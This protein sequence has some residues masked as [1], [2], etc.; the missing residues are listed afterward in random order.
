MVQRSSDFSPFLTIQSLEGK[1][2]LSSRWKTN[3]GRRERGS[4]TEEEVNKAGEK[5]KKK[6]LATTWLAKEG[7][8]L[9]V[10]AFMTNYLDYVL[11]NMKTVLIYLR[12]KIFSEM[13]CFQL[14]MHHEPQATNRQYQVPHFKSFTNMNFFEAI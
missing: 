12:I 3:T 10:H 8:Y 14:F 5:V 1:E 13:H 11:C 7:T 6:F 9:S 2:K 4:A